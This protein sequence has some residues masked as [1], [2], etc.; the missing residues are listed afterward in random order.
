MR[1]ETSAIQKWMMIQVENI[2]ASSLVRP[3]RFESD[4]DGYLGYRVKRIRVAKIDHKPALR[5]GGSPDRARSRAEIIGK[6][7]PDVGNVGEAAP[8][9][10]G[11]S[12]VCSAGKFHQIMQDHRREVG[13]LHP[14]GSRFTLSRV[15]KITHVVMG[16]SRNGRTAEE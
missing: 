12:G 8:C 2:Q 5:V 3:G 1:N 7:F 15:T 4:A 14:R 16:E 10:M 11:G 6:R 9:L 13:K